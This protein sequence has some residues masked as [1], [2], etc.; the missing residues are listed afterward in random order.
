EQHHQHEQDRRGDAEQRIGPPFPHVL[1]WLHKMKGRR[2]ARAL[3]SPCWMDFY[4]PASTLFSSAW[5]SAR[6]ALALM[7]LAL[8]FLI[9]SSMIGA[10]RFCASA[11]IAG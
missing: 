1:D 6:I 10:E 8:A 2:T 5:N 3:W 9:Q 11:R 7:H 4:L